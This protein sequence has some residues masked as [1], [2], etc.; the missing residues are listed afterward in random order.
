M[1]TRASIFFFFFVLPKLRLS[2]PGVWLRFFRVTVH[3]ATGFHSEETVFFCRVFFKPLVLAQLDSF[4]VSDSSE[5]G[6]RKHPSVLKSVRSP[7]NHLS[8][9]AL[10]DLQGFSITPLQN[11]SFTSPGSFCFT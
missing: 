8:D 5:K 4:P 7:F 6:I 3:K 10:F 11:G 2:P 9:L 1:A